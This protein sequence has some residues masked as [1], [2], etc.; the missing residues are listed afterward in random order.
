MPRVK[1]ARLLF[2][3]VLDHDRKVFSI[4]EL[5]D[6]TAHNLAVTKAQ[7]AGR[8]MN[9]QWVTEAR[10]RDNAIRIV[11]TTFPYRLIDNALSK[12]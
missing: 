8:N 10:T 3:A 4:H 9:C 1:K 12:P 6:D 11:T 2:L 5:A 7:E